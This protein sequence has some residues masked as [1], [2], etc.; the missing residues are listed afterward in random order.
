MYHFLHLIHL[1]TARAK[2]DEA[3]D[4]FSH[5]WPVVSTVSQGSDR[6]VDA[7]VASSFEEVSTVVE[8]CDDIP[9]VCGYLFPCE[10]E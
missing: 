9:L 4:M 8:L 2:L 1:L 7:A 3:F 6:A 10:V 5:G